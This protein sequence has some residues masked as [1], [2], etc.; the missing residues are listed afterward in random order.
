MTIDIEQL[1]ILARAAY[2][3]IVELSKEICDK[4]YDHASGIPPIAISLLCCALCEGIERARE[5]D[6]DVAASLGCEMV[7][8]NLNIVLSG[9]W[10]QQK[11]PSEEEAMEI[12]KRKLDDVS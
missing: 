12:L 9:R 5:K 10:S 7:R 3:E 1:T 2:P 8:A 4:V 11:I 6:G